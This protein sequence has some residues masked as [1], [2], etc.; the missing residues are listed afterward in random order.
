M[1]A[2]HVELSASGQVQPQNAPQTGGVSGEGN[3]KVYVVGV[4][5][6]T[7]ITAVKL[8]DSVDSSGPIVFSTAAVGTYS[9]NYELAFLNGCYAEI[10][11][12][13]TV[14]IWVA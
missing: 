12:T 8:H 14:S 2:Q 6:G 11:G 9:W 10:S 5:V 3:R 7:G 4:N 13:G 1:Q